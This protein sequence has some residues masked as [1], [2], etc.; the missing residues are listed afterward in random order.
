MMTHCML[1]QARAGMGWLESGKNG[2][3]G[4]TDH[5][6]ATAAKTGHE[7]VPQCPRS[8]IMVL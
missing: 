4:N 7:G 1:N 3:A 5:A 2:T 8:S 6:A